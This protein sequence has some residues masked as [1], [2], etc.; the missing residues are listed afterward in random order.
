MHAFVD[1]ALD[2]DTF[3]GLLR[4]AGITTT[5]MRDRFT[6]GTKDVD[7][8]PII[9]GEGLVII[10]S[11]MRTRRRK[12]EVDCLVRAKARVL[13]L[14]ATR[15]DVLGHNVANALPQIRRAFE[16]HPPPVAFK[17]DRP[18]NP[19]AVFHGQSGRLRKRDFFGS[20]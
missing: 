16:R 5:R 2:S 3:V 20:R 13:Y 17:L 1:E 8:I 9:A 15:H 11:D 10:T 4:H 7:W 6:P 18:Q 14:P 19:S 12:V